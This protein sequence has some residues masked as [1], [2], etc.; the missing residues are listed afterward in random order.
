MKSSLQAIQETPKEPQQTITSLQ[1][2]GAMKEEEIAPRLLSAIANVNGHLTRVFCGTSH[3]F[4]IPE[5]AKAL[6]LKT[7]IV[8][9]S[10]TMKSVNS[11]GQNLVKV[12]KGV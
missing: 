6:G 3:I 9:E 7:K 10:K 5:K 11:P 1:L 2:F 4:C 12:V 8:N